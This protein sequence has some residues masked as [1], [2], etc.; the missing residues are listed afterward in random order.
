MITVMLVLGAVA[1]FQLMGLAFRS[2]IGHSIFRLAVV[3][4]KGE[5]ADVVTLLRRWGIVWLPLF[6]PMS[7]AT[8]LDE[9]AGNT[10]AFIYALVLLVLWIGAAVYAVIHPNRGLHDRLASTWV[11]RR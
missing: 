4:T 5:L 6:L 3:N 8:L 1:L 11:V 7:F 10:T 2:T 9:K